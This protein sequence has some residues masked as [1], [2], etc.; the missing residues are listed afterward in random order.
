MLLARGWTLFGHFLL[1]EHHCLEDGFVTV[2]YRAQTSSKFIFSLL[3]QNLF[4][5]LKDFDTGMLVGYFHGL[6]MLPVG[7][8]R[9]CI[10]PLKPIFELASLAPLLC[11]VLLKLSL[12]GR[13][14]GLEA[15]R[16]LF[17][18]ALDCFSLYFSDSCPLHEEGFFVSHGL[19]RFYLNP[20]PPLLFTL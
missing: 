1:Q 8:P 9:F 5:H 7:S 15:G 20:N 11:Q 6:R 16:R 18:V 4:V 17:N 13:P 2:E 3:S 19:S 12:V 10:L 14:L